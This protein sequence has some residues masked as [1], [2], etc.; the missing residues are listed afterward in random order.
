MSTRYS[1][2][3]T[4]LDLG[5]GTSQNLGFAHRSDV[6][7]SYGEETIT[8][9]NLLELRRRHPSII[10]LETFSKKKEAA[11]GAD[12]EWH[13]I[14]RRRTLR[15]RVQAKRLQKDDKLKIPHK[16]ASSGKQQI[17]LLIA[18]AK[19]QSMH[20]VYCFYSSER[21]RNHWK[22]GFSTGGGFFEA[23]CLLAS[24]HR[25]K[26]IMPTSL[27]AIERYSVPWHY[28][29]DQRRFERL[30]LLE[31]AGEDDSA[32]QFPS[33]AF[34]IPINGK[35]DDKSDTIDAFPTIDDLNIDADLSRSYEGVVDT[36]EERIRPSA[37]TFLERGIAK[38]IEIDVREIPP[39]A[40][41]D[42]EA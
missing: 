10:H 22:T 9:T 1:L 30:G 25:V 26:S 23:G 37:H 21:Q 12:W 11:L 15:M 2:L 7:V 36:A 20:P 28:L 29:V 39:R 27:P 32:I 35:A 5:H 13:I 19:Q 31:F 42:E 17:D 40:P 14:G 24:A 3:T 41:K 33:S 38:L 34:D 6:F 16:V 8:E 4:L 18:D